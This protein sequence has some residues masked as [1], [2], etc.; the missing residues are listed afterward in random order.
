MAPKGRRIFSM[1]L[2]TPSGGTPPAH[3]N[4]ARQECVVLVRGGV[5]D[6]LKMK[7]KVEVEVALEVDG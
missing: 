5:S 4:N 2:Q 1:L 6:A 7:L 3:Q